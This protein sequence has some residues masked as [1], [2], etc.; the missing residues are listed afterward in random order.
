MTYELKKCFLEMK[1]KKYSLEKQYIFTYSNKKF[2]RNQMTENLYSN[3]VYILFH[4]TENN[5]KQNVGFT[6]KLTKKL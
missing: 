3:Y 6:K 2:T 4:T 1:L 5:R